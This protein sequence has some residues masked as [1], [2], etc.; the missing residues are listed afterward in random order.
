[1]KILIIVGHPN[2]EKSRVN[3]YLLSQVESEKNITIHY[4]EKEYLK[5]GM[6]LPIHWKEEQKLILEHDRIILQ[7]PFYWYSFPA[8]MKRWVDEILLE[9]TYTQNPIFAKK[10]FLFSITTGG[11]EVAYSASGYNNYSI[12]QFTLPFEQIMNLIQAKYLSPFL[13]QGT[14]HHLPDEK[15]KE[16]GQEYKAYIQ[17]EKLS[18]IGKIK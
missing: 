5:D 7:F 1:M 10:E 6:I 15:L 11:N 4:L 16:K 3:K 12:S 18:A 13:V 9:N 8:L 17:S 14:M 2:I